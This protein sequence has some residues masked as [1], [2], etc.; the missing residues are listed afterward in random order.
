MIKELRLLKANEIEVRPAHKVGDKISM[1]LYIDSRVVNKKLDEWVGCM[2]WQTEFY[3]VNDQI[4]GKLGIWDDSKNMW[5]WKSDV[6][7][8]SNIEKEKGLIS[9]C[10]KRLLARWGQSELYS[11][12]DI[13]LPDDGYGNKGYKVSEIEYNDN[14]QIT[15]LVITNRFGKEMFRWGKDKTTSQPAPQPQIEYKDDELMWKPETE[16]NVVI[17]K[18]KTPVE[19]LI[20]WYNSI[21]HTPA[22]NRFYNYYMGKINTGNWKGEMKVEQLWERWTK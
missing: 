22:V 20:D 11:A 16:N 9:D 8:E 3:D 5:V 17:P 2:N 15:H 18:T 13:I 19:T 21:E 6:G 7:S 1:L 4:I 14:R 10:Y 12:P